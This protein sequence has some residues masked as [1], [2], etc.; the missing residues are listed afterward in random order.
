MLRLNYESKPIQGIYNPLIT[1]CFCPGDRIFVA[2][3]HRIKSVQCHFLWDMNT[4]TVD[5][6]IVTVDFP[7]GPGKGSVTQRNFPIKSFY[8]GTTEEVYTF[9]RQGFVFTMDLSSKAM[10]SD[11]Y[12]YQHLKKFVQDD[13]ELGPMYLI[14]DRAMVTQSSGSI[15]FFKKNLENRWERYTKLGGKRGQLYFIKGNDRFQITTD[16]RIYFYLID[17]E[18]LEPSLENVM[19]NYMNCAQMMFGTS[20]RFAVTFK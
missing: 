10:T 12:R 19:F 5:G 15:L 13:S 11:G 20:A 2:A 18:T 1:C 4:N 6:G 14:F 16:E 3:Y 7:L 8:S 9:Y 17:K